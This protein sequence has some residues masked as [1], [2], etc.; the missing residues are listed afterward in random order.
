[1]HWWLYYFCWFLILITSALISFIKNRIIVRN[2]Y[3][4]INLSISLRSSL[5]SRT[6]LTFSIFSNG[7][8]SF[9]QLKSLFFQRRT[10]FGNLGVTVLIH[11]HALGNVHRHEI[12]QINYS[13]TPAIY[14][15]FFCSDTL[16]SFCAELRAL[17]ITC[18]RGVL[19]LLEL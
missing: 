18:G 2:I 7:R 15:V 6:L 1:M 3:L 19:P 5:L 10:W 9:P 16:L 14:A 4:L 11:G 8:G 13:L 12:L 17:E